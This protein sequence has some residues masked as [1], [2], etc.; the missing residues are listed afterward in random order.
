[1]HRVTMVVFVDFDSV[2]SSFCPILLGQVKIGQ[3]W[4]GKLAE[5]LNVG[6][7]NVVSNHHGHPVRV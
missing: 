6:Q 2:C 5:L 7:Q 4:H 1:M 3:R